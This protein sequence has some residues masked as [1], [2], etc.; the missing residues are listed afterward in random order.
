MDYSFYFQQNQGI[1]IAQTQGIHI[2]VMRQKI[3]FQKRGK[4]VSDFQQWKDG[5][6]RDKQFL[7]KFTLVIDL[8]GVFMD[9]LNQNEKDQLDYIEKHSGTKNNFVIVKKKGY[10]QMVCQKKC[11]ADIC[12]C[13]VRIYNV[14]PYTYEFLSCLSSQYEIIGA[15]NLPRYEITQMIKSLEDYVNKIVEEKNKHTK[16]LFKLEQQYFDF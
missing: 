1:F 14:R 3:D 5:F 15:A 4:S 16:K 10:K 13:K 7:K 11:K 6:R 9:E 12:A 8:V 2:D